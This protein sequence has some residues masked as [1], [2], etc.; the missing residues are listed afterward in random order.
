[1]ENVVSAIKASKMYLD[2]Q[3][4]WHPISTIKFFIELYA[5]GISYT[6]KELEKAAKEMYVSLY[7]DLIKK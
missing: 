5:S 1:M 2:L 4:K 3:E 7:G 6:N